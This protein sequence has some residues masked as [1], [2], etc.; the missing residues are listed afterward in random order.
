[1]IA[2]TIAITCVPEENQEESQTYS[3][4]ITIKVSGANL[5]FLKSGLL[6]LVRILDTQEEVCHQGT[7]LQLLSV[8]AM[9]HERF[10]LVV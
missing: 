1:M 9:L 2:S 7:H 10:P 8:A 3:S 6:G 4:P 5:L